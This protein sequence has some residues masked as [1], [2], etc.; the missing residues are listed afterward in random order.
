[1]S[2][3]SKIAP[4]SAL[5]LLLIMASSPHAS[6]QTGA[7]QIV[8]QS[9]TVG[10]GGIF[11]MDADGSNQLRLVT[12][13]GD[14][15]AP[16]W[17]RDGCRIVFRRGNHNAGEGFIRTSIYVMNA[18]GSNQRLLVGD[19]DA[20]LEEDLRSYFAP[21]GARIVFVSQS[22]DI[23]VINSDGS[24]VR[25]L[26][27]GLYA[28]QPSWS[29]DGSKIL[30]GSAGRPP[31]IRVANADGA[32]LQDIGSGTD[33]QWSPDGSR[34]TFVSAERGHSDIAVMSSDGRHVR[35]LTGSSGY[36]R[37]PSWS[38]DGSRIAFQTMRQDD[39][40]LEVMDADGT[41]RT[42]LADHLLFEMSGA[43]APSWSPNGSEVA[44]TR[45]PFP[46]SEITAQALSFD[47]YAVGADGSNLRRLTTTGMA[48]H[49]TWSPTP[50]CQSG[51]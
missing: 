13:I 9:A 7:P 15:L 39:V 49:P 34:I 37:L 2:Q 12:G 26:T 14:A 35:V 4:L 29:P 21:D 41:R 11:V 6:A 20:G 50:R 16:V 18:D 33:A 42:T 40:L 10:Q 28:F 17:S 51:P 46:L 31:R 25:K 45:M 1:M 32:G 38:P 5:A 19:V 48:L 27:D 47:I 24:G 8:F 44:F 43:M 36:A 30:F 3:E 23:M 22:N